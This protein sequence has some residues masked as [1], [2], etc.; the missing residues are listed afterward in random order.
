MNVATFKP[1]TLSTDSR[2]IKR[3]HQ[4]LYLGVK[5]DDCLT[6]KPNFNNIFKKFSN[7]IY[8]FG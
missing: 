4:Y 8:Q 7:K 6:M 2:E 5:L 1:N 3:C